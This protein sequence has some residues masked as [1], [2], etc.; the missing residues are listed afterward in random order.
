[1]G[2]TEDTVKTVVK[3]NKEMQKQQPVRRSTGVKAIA[4][5]KKIL[6]AQYRL[7]VAA[8]LASGAALAVYQLLVHLIH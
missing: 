3:R 4:I 6:L 8:L 5:D 1:V 2:R 7:L